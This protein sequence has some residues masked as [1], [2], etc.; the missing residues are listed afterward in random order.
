MYE[1]IVDENKCYLGMYIWIFDVLYN[2]IINMVID[3]KDF[4]IW[5]IVLLF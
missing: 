4:L 2:V 1:W 3:F 5:L